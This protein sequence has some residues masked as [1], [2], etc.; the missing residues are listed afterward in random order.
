MDT[1]KINKSR[2]QK[3]ILML[4]PNGFDPDPRVHNEARSLVNAGYSVT[5]LCW[6]REM[7]YPEHEV[8]D[9]IQIERIF[10]E[11]SYG[12][13]SSQLRYLWS[14]WKEAYKR[15][16]NLAPDVIHAHDFNTLPLGYSARVKN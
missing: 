5:I 16:I 6:D 15:A 10:I 2:M 7:K 9:G 3:N 11:S 14:F 13:G 4:L 12:R 1:G 8:V